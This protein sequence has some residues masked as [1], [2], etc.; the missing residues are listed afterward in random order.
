MKKKEQT[1]LFHLHNVAWLNRVV[2][3]NSF[4]TIYETLTFH[5]WPTIERVL[6]ILQAPP[7]S[8]FFQTIYK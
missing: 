3:K 2:I 4:L 5:R 1:F 6:M 8:R 7:L